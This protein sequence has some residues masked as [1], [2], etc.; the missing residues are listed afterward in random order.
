MLLHDDSMKR[1]TGFLQIPYLGSCLLSV[2][3]KMSLI[4]LPRYVISVSVWCGNQFGFKII[5]TI[6]WKSMHVKFYSQTRHYQPHS[7]VV[8]SEEINITV[9]SYCQKSTALG[10]KTKTNHWGLRPRVYTP[11]LFSSAMSPYSTVGDREDCEVTKSEKQM[12]SASFGVPLIMLSS[13][14]L[15]S[16]KT[17][18]CLLQASGGGMGPWVGCSILDMLYWRLWVMS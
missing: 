10:S 6:L 2:T 17:S 16:K 5:I 13:S 4:S 15:H 3:Q 9:Y 14:T 11:L 1:P 8:K 7:A 12:S 18:F